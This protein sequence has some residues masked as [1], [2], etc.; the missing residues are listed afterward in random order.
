MKRSADSEKKNLIYAV[1]LYL[2]KNMFNI[3]Q[4]TSNYDTTKE[5]CIMLCKSRY[6]SGVYERGPDLLMCVS[7]GRIITRQASA[8]SY[9]ITPRPCDVKRHCTGLFLG[10]I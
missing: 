9:L 2:N 1:I 10:L 3:Q 4:Y 6:I 8:D 5:S 7:T